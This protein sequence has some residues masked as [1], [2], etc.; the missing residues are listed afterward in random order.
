MNPENN[1]WKTTSTNYVIVSANFVHLCHSRTMWWLHPPL[2]L[3]H[4]PRLDL[5]GIPVYWRLSS[6]DY[7]WKKLVTCFCDPRRALTTPRLRQTFQSACLCVSC[8]WQLRSPL[9]R[10][11]VSWD[12]SRVS[13]SQ[14]WIWDKRLE[15]RMKTEN[16][17]NCSVTLHKNY[18]PSSDPHCGILDKCSDPKCA[19]RR[20]EERRPQWQSRTQHSFHLNNVFNGCGRFH[21]RRSE[22]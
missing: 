7:P 6:K 22:E 18:F 12:L 13:L 3:V 15:L 2:I 1:V 20:Q 21:R 16:H 19:T 17:S 10:S 8:S 11:W 5:Q 9:L 14:R 4:A